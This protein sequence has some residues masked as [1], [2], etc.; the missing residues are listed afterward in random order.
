MLQYSCPSIAPSGLWAVARLEFLSSCGLVKCPIPTADHHC[1]SALPF[2][3]R[4]TSVLSMQCFL[5]LRPRVP[6]GLLHLPDGS[7]RGTLY[8]HGPSVSIVAHSTLLLRSC[9][10]LR[11]I[12]S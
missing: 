1:Q 3:S 6:C 5:L 7:L 4:P 2:P 10:Y 12:D 9:W 11:L 8:P